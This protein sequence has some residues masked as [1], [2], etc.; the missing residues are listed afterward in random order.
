MPSLIY[1]YVACNLNL[2][3]KLFAEIP[4]NR[5]VS[6]QLKI[7]EYKNLFVNIDIMD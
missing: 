4:K 2:G 5:S 7:K 6:V 3:V 1:D